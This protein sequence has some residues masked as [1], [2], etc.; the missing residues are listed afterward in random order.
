MLVRERRELE[1]DKNE[2]R[3]PQC[4]LKMDAGEWD[5]VVLQKV[6]ERYMVECNE[7]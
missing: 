1:A 7:G 6:N 2:S 5:C 4:K 3:C